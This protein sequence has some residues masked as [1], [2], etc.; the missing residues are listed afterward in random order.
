MKYEK[1]NNPNE[2][3]NYM[4]NI[5]YGFI[6]NDKRYVENDVNKNISLWHLSSVEQTLNKQIGICYDQVELERDWFTKHNYEFKTYFLIFSLPYQNDGPTHTFLIYKDKEKYY[7]FEHSF[8]ENKGIYSFNNLDDTLNFVY[9]SQ[10]KYAKR[11]SKLNDK[12][13]KTLTM[14]EYNK[15]KDNVNFEDFIVGILEEN[16]KIK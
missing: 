3:L 14:Y 2:L 7:Y 9:N 6:A 1:I 12:E 4:D 5:E 16:L 8:E 11:Y 15:P 13:L 10:L